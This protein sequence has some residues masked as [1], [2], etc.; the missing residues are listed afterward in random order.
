MK[1]SFWTVLSLDMPRLSFALFAF[2]PPGM[3]VAKVC[4]PISILSQD[5][6][7]IIRIGLS[8]YFTFEG[9]RTGL[10]GGIT[11]IHSQNKTVERVKRLKMYIT[12]NLT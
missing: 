1:V 4:F 11:V 9:H 12:I 10:D 3:L 7:I 2:G 8:R 5:Q 6:M